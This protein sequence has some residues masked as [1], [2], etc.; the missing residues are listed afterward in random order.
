MYSVNTS[1]P[2]ITFAWIK[3]NLNDLLVYLT[4]EKHYKLKKE[5]EKGNL[6]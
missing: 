1:E 5:E 4:A 6:K 3:F 2:D